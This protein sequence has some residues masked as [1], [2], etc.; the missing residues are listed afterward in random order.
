MLAFSS[1]HSKVVKIGIRVARIQS[2]L[3]K[4][5]TTKFNKA[6][7][8]KFQEKE[9][10]LNE[11]LQKSSK[12]IKARQ[13]ETEGNHTVTRKNLAVIPFVHKLSEW[14]KNV[15]STKLMYQAFATSYDRYVQRCKVNQK[16]KNLTGSKSVR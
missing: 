11:G 8:S 6:S 16:G 2:S 3:F 5:I 4:L 12:E 9:D 10:T 14:I 13:K 15:G 7:Q 1:D